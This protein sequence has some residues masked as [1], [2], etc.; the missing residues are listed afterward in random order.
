MTCFRI[1]RF[2]ISEIVR[3]FLSVVKHVG[4]VLKNECRNCFQELVVLIILIIDV[5]VL[6]LQ[7]ALVRR[8]W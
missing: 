7:E 5:P 4:K 2:V 8:R 6:H 1:S 3:L